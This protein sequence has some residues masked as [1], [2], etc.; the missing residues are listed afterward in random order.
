M[1]EHIAWFEELRSSDVAR[2][3]GT[4]ALLGELVRAL[5]GAGVCVPSGPATTATVY[6]ELS[7]RSGLEEV[8]AAVRS[9]RQRRGAARGTLR[10][11]AGDLPQLAQR[12]GAAC[13]LPAL[14]CLATYPVRMRGTQARLTRKRA[15]GRK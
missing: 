10:R 4:N 11:P 5:K 13:G 7:R 9:S 1:S 12:A 8:A 6:R 15:T 3:G 2:I 14:L